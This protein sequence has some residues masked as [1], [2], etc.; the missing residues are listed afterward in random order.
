MHGEEGNN[1]GTVMC[2]STVE[3]NL[4]V[5]ENKA[6]VGALFLSELAVMSPSHSADPITLTLVYYGSD[7]RQKPM[8]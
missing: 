8:K 4:H 6:S 7:V 1:G 3:K 5:S 2:F